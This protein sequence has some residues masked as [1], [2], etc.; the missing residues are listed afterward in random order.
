MGQNR[1]SF[2]RLSDPSAGFRA[3]DYVVLAPDP[4]GG[5][6]GPLLPHDASFALCSAT[7]AC[8]V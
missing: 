4:C 7:A 6:P 5:R 3:A 2:R 8:C 1:E